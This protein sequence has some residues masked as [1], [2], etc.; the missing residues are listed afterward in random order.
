MFTKHS[1]SKILALNF[2]KKTAIFRLNGPPLLHQKGYNVVIH[3]R[4]VEC[5]VWTLSVWTLMQNTSLGM[6]VWKLETP[7]LD[8]K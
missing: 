8:T 2:E 1:P 3:S 7:V 5:S 4:A 6:R